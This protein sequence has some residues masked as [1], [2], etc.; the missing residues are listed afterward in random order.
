VSRGTF[1]Q[2]LQKIFGE[3]A[4]GIQKFYFLSQNSIFL[5]QNSIYG[6]NLI[7]WKKIFAS[8]HNSSVGVGWLQN[9]AEVAV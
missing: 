3:A 4:I 7:F 6:Q 2:R 9:L 8:G 5:H 1:L